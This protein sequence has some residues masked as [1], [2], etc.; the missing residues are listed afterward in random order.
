MLGYSEWRKFNPVIEKSMHSFSGIIFNLASSNGI[1]I[2]DNNSAAWANCYFDTTNHYLQTIRISKRAHGASVELPDYY[3]TRLACYAIAMEAD[4]RK[5]EV[6]MAKQYLLVLANKAVD[7][8]IK[9]IDNT[10]RISMRETLTDYENS[11]ESTYANSGVRSSQY[12]IVKSEGDKGFYNNPGGTKAVKEELGIP[13]NKT[14]YDYMPIETMI[15]K[16]M[17]NYN[18]KYS[19]INNEAK[20]L[21]ECSSIAFTQNKNQREHMYNMQGVYP[22]ET[23][24]AEN[25]TVARREVKNVNKNAIKGA[26]CDCIPQNIDP[27]IYNLEFEYAGRRYNL[28][29][30]CYINDIDPNYTL[31]LIDNGIP[32]DQAIFMRENGA[33]SPIILLTPKL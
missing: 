15:N 16:A 7:D 25:I 31:S 17:A 12:G 4:N 9:Y 19:I 21:E 6:A 11:L 13:N 8:H 26:L 24:P 3:L 33:K 20:G 10:Q 5:P 23:M 14:L 32:F 1:N 2:G 28:G 22:E 18:T 29:Q 30:W 27:R